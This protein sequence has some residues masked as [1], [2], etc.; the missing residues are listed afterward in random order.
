MKP[1]VNRHEIEE[2]TPCDELQC[3]SKFEELQ[4]E[5]TVLVKEP[6]TE[7]AVANQSAPRIQSIPVVREGVKSEQKDESEECSEI[8]VWSQPKPKK[9]APRHQKGYNFARHSTVQSRQKK[10]AHPQYSH[11]HSSVFHGQQQQQRRTQPLKAKR[12]MSEQ[13]RMFHKAATVHTISKRDRLAANYVD[14]KANEPQLEATKAAQQK[15][16][17]L[18]AAIASFEQKSHDAEVMKQSSLESFRKYQALITETEAALDQRLR[19]FEKYKKKQHRILCQ[20][21]QDL[22]KKSRALLNVPDRKQRAQIELVKAQNE[23]MKRE[24]A[25]KEKR[26][27]SKIERLKKQNKKLRAEK[28]EIEGELKKVKQ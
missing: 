14:R 12:V 4:I 2:K 19:D 17:E 22:D 28:L 26:Y 3:A 21:T 8:G 11:H 5:D 10:A 25:E 27:K 18:E 16:G 9:M 13:K 23:E 15:A 20:K 7:S 6:L 24:F 1:A